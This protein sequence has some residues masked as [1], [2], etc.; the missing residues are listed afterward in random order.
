MKQIF[1]PYSSSNQSCPIKR[2]FALGLFRPIF[3]MIILTTLGCKAQHGDQDHFR[4]YN[5]VEFE[6]KV[7][8]PK[9]YNVD[10]SYKT[11]I[12]FAGMDS[13]KDLADWSVHNLWKNHQ[14]YNSIIVVPRVPVGKPHWISH[15]I[16]HALNDFIK[17]IHK[18]YNVDGGKVDFVGYKDGCIPA[19]TYI[20]ML[21]REP[22]SLTLFSSQYWEHY[23]KSTFD[24]LAAVNI[25]V[26]I[27][28]TGDDSKELFRRKHVEG[29]LKKRKVKVTVDIEN[30]AVSVLDRLFQ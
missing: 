13:D 23:N 20:T 2:F 21:N 22:A 28:Y 14:N 27:Y 7:L 11:V 29:E 4:A 3:L 19:Q 18:T 26:R 30:D 17:Y 15:P 6:Y 16:H 9:N 12:A 25:P 24:E 5:G 1:Y 10:K 8:L